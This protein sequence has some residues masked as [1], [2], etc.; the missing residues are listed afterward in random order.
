MNRT[1]FSW[2]PITAVL[3][4]ALACSSKSSNSNNDGSGGTTN[5]GTT[6]SG[7]TT[8]SSDGGSSA[9]GSVGFG[10]SIATTTIGA[11]GAGG[12]N[13]TTS[14]LGGA[15]GAAGETTD[16]GSGGSAGASD[17]GAGGSGGS[18]SVTPGDPCEGSDVEPNDDHESTTP[19]ELGTAFD[20][21]LQSAE[22]VDVYEF[23]I[24]E[25]D[26]GGV[27]SVSIT[28]V[29]PNGDTN[30]E[31]W[32]A[33]DDGEFHST[34]SNTEGASV[35]FY[36]N[37]APGATFRLVVT[38][39]LQVTEPNP[40]RLTVDY[41]QVPDEHEPNQVRGEAVAIE[42]DEDVEGYLFAGWI[43]S[44]GVAEEDWYDWYSVELEAGETSFLVDVMASDI[45]HEIVLYD[46]IGTQITS[47]G[48]NTEGSSVLL[49]HE[50]PEA[51]KYFVR[52]NPYIP[53]DTLGNS[54]DTP[55]YASTPYTL[56]IT[57]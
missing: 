18:S 11:G 33:A 5:S 53:P 38:K 41:D 44:T 23:S 2:L 13:V 17:G 10:G 39:Y 19:Y 34:G 43:N 57:Q 40:Y 15:A 16:A 20:G 26:R 14:S 32:A 51:G 3:A 27:A 56:T 31:L 42:V 29:G 37:A 55:E 28:E 25:D 49:E 24:P 47:E 21:C 30:V 54:L 36:F 6:S 35:Y 50:V 9:G 52:V 4:G 12:S 46:P 8:S 22:D 1:V 45:D 7:G 48:T